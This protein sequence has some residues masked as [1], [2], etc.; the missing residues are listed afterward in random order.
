MFNRL[1][2]ELK[3]NLPDIEQ[4]ESYVFEMEDRLPEIHR[5]LSSTSADASSA[6]KV[7]SDAQHLMPTAKQTVNEGLSTIDRT[8]SFLNQAEKKLNEMSPRIEEDLQKVLNISKEA[9]DFLTK[10]NQMKLDFT[11]LDQA[12]H[13]LDQQLTDSLQRIDTIQS[14]LIWLRDVAQQ[15]AQNSE[16]PQAQERL[17]RIQKAIDQT[18]N[19]KSLMQEAQA[20]GRNLNGLLEGREQQLHKALTDLQEITGNTTIRLEGFISEY[21][22][23]IRPAIISETASAKKTLSNARSILT[24]IQTAIPEVERLLANT[25]GN[26]TEGQKMLNEALNQYPYISD[27]VNRLADRIRTIQGEANIQD[28]I[29]LLINN[30]QAERSF[31]EE[32][33]VL[34]ETKLFPIK[35]YGTGMTPFYT[36]LSIWVGCLLL[37]SLLATDIE[38]DKGLTDRQ[39]YVG[40]YLTFLSIGMLQTLIVTIGDLFILHVDVHNP[41]W[42]VLFGLLISTVF[43]VIVYTFVSLLGDVGKA[44][45]IVMLVLQIAGSGGTYPVVLLPKFFQLINPFLP[46]TYGVD[47]MR[48]A[49]GGIVWQRVFNDVVFLVITWIVVFIA[50]IFLKKL[51]NRKTHQLFRKSRES[52]LF[53]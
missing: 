9:N 38:S 20:N 44:L 15:E 22:N 42:F 16:D 8:L 28:I 11:E 19:I 12:K 26:I 18:G 25:A 48:E 31:F 47:I 21:R 46:F 37:I 34:N 14:D 29:Q 1:G 51:V 2:I 45:A 6:Q 35:N 32:P 17:D 13:R 33:I 24:S 50:G 23:E 49:V 52:G 10:A 27:K 5:L 43:M 4:F 40:K 7:I 53:H 36:V 30:P 41:G 3:Q 39:V